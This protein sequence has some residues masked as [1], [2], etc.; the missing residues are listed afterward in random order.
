MDF[1]GE[2]HVDLQLSWIGLFRVST[3]YLHLE[4]SKLQEVFLSKSN[5]SL[6]GKQCG[7]GT[8]SNTDG[9]LSGDPC[10]TSP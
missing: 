5:S 9:F 6:T 1:F 7:K 4:T 2:I 8:C 3:G 10:V